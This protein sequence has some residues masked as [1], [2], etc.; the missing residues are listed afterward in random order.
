[1]LLHMQKRAAGGRQGRHFE[2]DVTQKSDSVNP[3]IHLY[4][5]K[6]FNVTHHKARRIELDEKVT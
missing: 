5:L 3:S 4:L 2:Y 6:N 1:M